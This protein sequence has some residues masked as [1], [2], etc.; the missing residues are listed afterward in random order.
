MNRIRTILLAMLCLIPQT[1]QAAYPVTFATLAAGNQ[2]LSLLD[3]MFGVVGEMGQVQCTASGA[4]AIALSP[5]TNM[6][7]ITSYV[8][9]QE[10]GFVAAATS[11]DPV[12]IEVSAIGDLPLYLSDGITQADAGSIQDTVYYQ[13]VYNS[14]L[15]SGTGGF[16]LIGSSSGSAVSDINFQV[17]TSSGTFTPTL[18]GTYKITIT[19]GGGGGGFGNNTASGGGAA[20]TSI[21][22]ASLT[23]STA[24]TVTV[25]GSGAGGTSGSHNGVSGTDSTI[26]IGPTTYT[27]AGGNGGL[28]GTS[29]SPATGGS[30][31]G[32]N[33]N[34][35]G[36]DAGTTFSTNFSGG[37]GASLWGGGGFGGT[38]GNNNC[39]TGNAYGSGGGG[40]LASNG[41]AGAGGIVTFEWIS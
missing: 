23:A 5:I 34:I 24:Y 3:T 37:G 6:P 20:G 4:N 33:I 38:N 15:N 14:A 7:T 1:A 10:F 19:G 16:Q 2:S 17:F 30:A 32:G 9:Y 27:G 25:G 11:T 21:V 8:D 26:V 36:G 31:T 13:I 35:S 40:G 41:C 18:T 12:T 28:S 29:T 22:W 39:N